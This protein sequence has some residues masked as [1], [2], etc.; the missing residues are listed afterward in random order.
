MPLSDITALEHSKVEFTSKLSKDI[1]VE[2]VRWFLGEKELKTNDK[3][4]F[5]KD[6][7]TQKLVI[8]DIAVEDEGQVTIQ[9]LDKKTTASLFVQ[10]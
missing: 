4:Q 3:V 5:L 1:P 7:L 10:G 8:K 2:S 6:G 9:V